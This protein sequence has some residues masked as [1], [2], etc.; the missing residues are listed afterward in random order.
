[1]PLRVVS[2]R[3]TSVGGQRPLVDM[4]DTDRSFHHHKS[5]LPAYHGG[6]N[7]LDRTLSQ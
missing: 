5:A 4:R 7:D 2:A 6:M 3:A 1:M